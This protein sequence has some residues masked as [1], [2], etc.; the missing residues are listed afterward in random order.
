[1]I[2]VSSSQ[3][4]EGER[5]AEECRVRGNTR[6]LAY[7]IESVANAIRD[8]DMTADEWNDIGV[9]LATF[10]AAVMKIEDNIRESEPK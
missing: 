6:S 9:E 2:T 4:R 10:L 1:M 8:G 3:Q 5:I 7:K